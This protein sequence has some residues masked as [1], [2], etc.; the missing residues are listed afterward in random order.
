MCDCIEILFQ[1]KI[2]EAAQ[3]LKVKADTSLPQAD[4]API[5]FEVS[6]VLKSIH[7]EDQRRQ[8]LFKKKTTK[9]SVTTNDEQS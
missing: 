4:A 3:L 8:K 6:K 9:L 5:P 1:R 2:E 7:Q